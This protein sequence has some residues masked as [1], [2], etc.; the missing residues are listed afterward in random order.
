MRE[1]GWEEIL[2]EH[3]WLADPAYIGTNAIIPLKKPAGGEPNDHDK[4]YCK[5]IS[6]IRSAVE[7]AMAHLK[8]GRSLPPDTAPD[9]PNCRRSFAPSHGWNTIGSAGDQYG[10]E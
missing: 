8:T 4:A 7:R 3:T 9:L 6:L 2:K 1:V 10:S 5:Q